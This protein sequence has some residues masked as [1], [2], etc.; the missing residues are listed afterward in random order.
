MAARSFAPALPP[1]RVTPPTATRPWSGYQYSVPG[2]PTPVTPSPSH[3]LTPSSPHRIFESNR[4]KVD[5]ILARPYDAEVPFGSSGDILWATSPQGWISL[6]ERGLGFA[7]P[8]A[9]GR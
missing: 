3:P 1:A 2:R 8:T 7:R 9:P 4:V 5:K 6:R